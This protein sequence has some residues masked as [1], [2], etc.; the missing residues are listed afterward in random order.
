MRIEEVETTPLV[1]RIIEAFRD[2]EYPGDDAL[3]RSDGEPEREVRPF[4]RRRFHRWQ[5][6]EVEDV[7]NLSTVLMWLSPAGVRYYLPA[8]L[9]AAVAL[10]S[11]GGVRSAVL[12]EL[13]AVKNTSRDR[14]QFFRFR[15]IVDGLT[16]EQ[17]DVVRDSLT[18]FGVNIEQG[19][20]SFWR[21]VR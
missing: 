2:T 18:H 13:A 11:S 9:L 15:E 3:L 14:A 6:L 4:M 20:F 7:L 16:V 19:V 8:C 5:D 10:P 1:K 12:N 17:K 21:E